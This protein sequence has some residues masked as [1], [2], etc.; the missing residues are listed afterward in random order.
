[1]SSGWDAAAP[2]RQADHSDLADL[3]A[4]PPSPTANA[5]FSPSSAKG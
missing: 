2:R 5:T 1:M 4:S 3:D